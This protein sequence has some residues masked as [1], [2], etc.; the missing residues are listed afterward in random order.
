M[1]PC[2][3][4]PINKKDASDARVQVQVQTSADGYMVGPNREMDWMT[5]PRT[6][7]LNSYVDALDDRVDYIVLGAS[8]PRCG[9]WPTRRPRGLGADERHAL[10]SS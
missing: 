4:P 5:Q 8:S 10:A 9:A 3:E 2:T 1:Q 7:D 6:N